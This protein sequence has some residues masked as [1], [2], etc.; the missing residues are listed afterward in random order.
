MIECTADL[1]ESGKAGKRVMTLRAFMNERGDSLARP[2]DT[3]A[4]DTFF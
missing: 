3:Q 1:F 2:T 4:D